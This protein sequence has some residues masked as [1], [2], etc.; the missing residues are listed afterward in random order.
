[1]ATALQ[2]WLFAARPR[3]EDWLRSLEREVPLFMS[4]DIRN[5]GFKIASID[6]NLYPAG[7]NNLHESFHPLAIKQL[8]T[9]LQHRGV[10]PGSR[11]LLIGEEH[12]RNLFYLENLFVLQTLLIRAG[13]G[14]TTTTAYELEGEI[15]QNGIAALTTAKGNPI[16]LLNPTQIKSLDYAAIVMNHDSSSGTP[17]WIQMAP[18]PVLPTWRAGWHT[19]SKAR[20]FEHYRA[21]MTELGGIIDVDPWFLVPLDA[22][23]KGVDINDDSSRAEI[24]S[25]AEQLLA[26]IQARYN[27]HNNKEKPFVFLKSDHGTYGMAMLSFDAASEITT[28]NRKEKNKLFKG[29]SA[30]V[31]RDYLLQEGVPTVQRDGIFSAEQVVML[32][33][34]QFIGYFSRVNELK[35]ARTSLN[36]T[37]M[38]FRQHTLAECDTPEIAIATLVTRIAGI[39]LQREIEELERSASNSSGITQTA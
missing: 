12:T 16:H 18:I 19:R 38:F 6:A 34:N 27:E 13:F 21:L 33:N 4:A 25:K 39:A 23:I 9:A 17:E 14:V 24:A 29:K 22:H 7:F 3:I 35:D 11:L 2:D 36:S 20:H 37:G 15:Y 26:Q 32:A 8:T 5:A 10:T 1:M 28:I 31:V 30:V